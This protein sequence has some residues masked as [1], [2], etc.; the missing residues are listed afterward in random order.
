MTLTLDD[1]FAIHQTIA[2]YGHLI[3]ER[4]FSRLDEIFSDHAVFDLSP[5]GGEVHSGLNAII[6]MMCESREHPLAHH[7]SNIV[8]DD[9]GMST[10]IVAVVSKGLGVGFKGR[11]GSV[12]YKDKFVQLNGLWRIQHRLCILRSAESIPAIS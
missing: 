5:Y 11:V 2:L 6:K 12:V 9:A 3:D 10:G 1:K 7:A 8:I 4:Q